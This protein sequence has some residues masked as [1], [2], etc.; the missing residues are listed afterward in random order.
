MV[1]RKCQTA[2]ATRLSRGISSPFSQRR[3]AKHK[4]NRYS[5][6][7]FNKFLSPVP[8]ADGVYFVTERHF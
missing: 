4:E 7:N 8:I 6:A 2:T 1:S 3:A 5:A